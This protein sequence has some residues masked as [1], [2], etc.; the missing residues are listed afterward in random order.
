MLL[1]RA[2]KVDDPSNLFANASE[3][4]RIEGFQAPIYNG[5]V[6]AIFKFS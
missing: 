3:N 2:G 1:G 4:I 5:Q 6:T